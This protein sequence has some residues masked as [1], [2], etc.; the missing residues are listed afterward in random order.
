MAGLPASVC[1]RASSKAAE[2]AAAAAAAEAVRERERE[3]AL[4]RRAIELAAQG[5]WPEEALGSLQSKA[6]RLLRSPG[7]NS[8]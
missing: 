7:G 5:E 6:R 3:R 4:L 1:A 2:A 8:A